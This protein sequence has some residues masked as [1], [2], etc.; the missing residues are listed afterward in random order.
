[1][2]ALT[3]CQKT[4][5]LGEAEGGERE[6]LL[7]VSLPTWKTEEAQR[8]EGKPRRGEKNRERERK[9]EIVGRFFFC[10]LFFERES[11]EKTNEMGLKALL[12]IDVW[13][14]NC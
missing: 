3:L 6:S 10:S 9:G 11:E 13:T 5:F 1:M 14:A 8:R 7:G 2:N 4:W 12:F